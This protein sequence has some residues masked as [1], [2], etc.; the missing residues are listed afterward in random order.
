LTVE[1]L[2]TFLEKH[3]RYEDG[4]LICTTRWHAK[5]QVGKK[6]GIVKNGYNCISIMGRWY[7]THRLIFLLHYKRLPEVVDHRDRNK[8]NNKIENLRECTKSENERNR[9]KYSNNTSG[10]KGVWFHNQRQKWCAEITVNS[11]SIKL[12]LF[13]TPELASKA[14]EAASREQHQEFSVFLS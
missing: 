3:T 4:E 8:L 13:D 7:K 1:E 2:L 14:Y 10:Y 5:L 11:K 12:G 6:L 9:V